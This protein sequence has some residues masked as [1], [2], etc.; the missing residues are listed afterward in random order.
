MMRQKLKNQSG[1]VKKMKKNNPY[2][3]TCDCGCKKEHNF[4]Y[5]DCEDCENGIHWNEV[6]GRYVLY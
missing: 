3:C 6:L 5:E 1:G 2:L 4:Q